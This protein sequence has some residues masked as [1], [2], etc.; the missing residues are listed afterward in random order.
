M[1]LGTRLVCECV[2]DQLG[3][4]ASAGKLYG[5][6]DHVEERHRH[7]YEVNPK[8]VKELEEKGLKFVGHSTDGQRMEIMELKGVRTE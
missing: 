1:G 2:Q 4:L 8:Y 3:A 5:K 6:K 7:R